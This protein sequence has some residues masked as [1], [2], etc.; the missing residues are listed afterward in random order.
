M[1]RR[2]TFHI[3]LEKTGTD[4]F[5][6][7]CTEQHEVLRRGGTL[8]P[9]RSLAFAAYNH[10]PLVACYLDYPDFSI[11]S[12]GHARAEVLC[13]LMAEIETADVPAILISGEHFSSRFRQP[14]IRQLAVDFSGFDCRIAVV[15]REHRAR[16]YSAYSQAVLSGRDMTLEAY[17]DEVF[18]PGNPYMRYAE[19]IGA[20]E[21]MFG[22]D[23][24]AVFRHS[25]GQDIVPV[26]CAALIAADMPLTPARRYWDNLSIGSRATEWLRRANRAVNRL[27]GTSHPTIRAAMRGPRRGLARLLA[28]LAVRDDKSGWR[29][30]ECNERRLTEIAAADDA[31][32]QRH[33]GIALG[34]DAAAGHSERMKSST[35][36]K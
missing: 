11:R 8:Y 29:L 2:L 21:A 9:T 22:R 27:P 31:W 25:R 23:N 34:G 36:E 12:S 17:C 20:W 24:V 5:Q 28:K 15:V 6:R 4:S 32:L 18:D 35:A 16:L 33:Y 10:E 1:K 13:A 30:G 19:T 3:G 14:E 7:F 26:L